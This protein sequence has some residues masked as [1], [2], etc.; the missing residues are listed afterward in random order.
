MARH[1]NAAFGGVSVFDVD[2]NAPTRT[3]WLDESAGDTALVADLITGNNSPPVTLDHSGPG[4]GCVL[5]YPQANHMPRDYIIQGDGDTADADA[6]QLWAILD[7]QP[8]GE[9]GC[10]LVVDL[11]GYNEGP[12]PLRFEVRS[13][14]WAV[15]DDVELVPIGGTSWSARAQGLTPGSGFV[16]RLV[17]DD[18]STHFG[19]FRIKSVRLGNFR[20]AS[21]RPLM[22]RAPT[23]VDN[24]TELASQTVSSATV[25]DV[26]DLDTAEVQ[27]EALAI[28][29]YHATKIAQTQHAL[30]EMLTGGPAGTNITRVLTPHSTQSTWYDHGRLGSEFASMPLIGRIPLAAWSLGACP[31]D[32]GVG[33][34]GLGGWLLC[35]NAPGWTAAASATYRQLF[36]WSGYMPQ[37]RTNR[38]Q[39]IILAYSAD[40]SI[41]GE[42]TIPTA[43]VRTYDSAGTLV[44]TITEATWSQLGSSK[45]YSCGVVG[46]DHSPGDN[47]RVLL[48]INCPTLAK[49]DGSSLR[50]AGISL[51]L[52]DA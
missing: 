47:C 12:Q 15:I 22:S 32:G 16:Y 38:L 17:C 49:T 41:V 34:D 18:I 19:G 36:D 30:V 9:G 7:F 26:Q 46:I 27:T 4:N 10:T 13:T 33:E 51:G 42:S 45:W 24:S 23:D 39:C 14:A 2:P 31:E 25:I 28:S 20:Q 44:D 29:G 40:A 1:V 3:R 52:V 48:D 50:I 8:D 11:E 37:H 21:G 43:R 6:C 35:K 5:G